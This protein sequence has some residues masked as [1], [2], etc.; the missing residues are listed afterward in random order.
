[1]TKRLFDIVVSIIALLILSPVFL[2]VAYQVSRKLGN[3]VLFKQR[4]PGLNGALF[5]IVKFRTMTNDKDSDGNLLGNKERTP[6][7]GLFLRNS[8]LDEL[9]E[10][11]NVLRGSMSLVGPRPLKIEYLESYSE[12]QRKRHNVSP[13]I[14]GWAQINGRNAISWEERFELDVWYVENKTV[15]LDV[16]ILFL[17]VIKVIKKEDIDHPEDEVKGRFKGTNND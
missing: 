12:R 9:P 13:G 15:W 17:T 1:M 2:F 3:P 7:F 14:T 4:R 10:L 16:K 8:S 11:W 5:D 6:S